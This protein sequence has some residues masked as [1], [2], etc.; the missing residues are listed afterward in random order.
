MTSAA[1]DLDPRLDGDGPAVLDLP[2][3]HLRLVNDA[4]F[5]WTVLVP[6]RPGLVEITD[7]DAAGRAVLMEEIAAVAEAVK[8]LSGCAKLNVAALGNVVPQLHVHV[9]GRNPG[10]A[11]W[12]GPVF[13]VGTR[14]PLAD[15]ERA[16]RVAALRGFLCA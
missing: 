7:L 5:Y 12:P 14:V 9:L 13:G 10:D 4:R 16:A 2:L 11:A 15:T 8:A 1:F 3:C 6:R